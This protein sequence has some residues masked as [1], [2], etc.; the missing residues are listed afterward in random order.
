M[1]NL[2]EYRPETDAK[3]TLGGKFISEEGGAGL[4]SV[5]NDLISSTVVAII[6]IVAMVM[7]TQLEYPDSILTSPGVLPF[8]TGLCLIF[9]SISLTYSALKRRKEQPR[10]NKTTTKA[11][12]YYSE[13][14]F[15]QTTI[16]A[17]IVLIYVIALDQINFNFRYAT[18]FYTFNLSSFEV[19]SIPIIAVIL[20]Y[21]WRGKVLHCIALS[22]FIIFFLATVFR[23]GF[24]I[25]L[26]GSG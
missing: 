18:S 2:P 8:F 22:A 11:T 15:R 3:D 10:I 26:P 14:E 20:Y 6:G 17:V 24:Q 7:A 25:L 19:V 5:K 21:F 1:T 4:S 16:L 9:M 12:K 23:E 13:R